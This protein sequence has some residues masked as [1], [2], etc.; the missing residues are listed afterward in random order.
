MDEDG[1]HVMVVMMIGTSQRAPWCDMGRDLMGRE[2]GI[3]QGAAAD[4]LR[5]KQLE[6]TTIKDKDGSPI[7]YVGF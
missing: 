4:H 1:A 2:G 7:L 5:R 3:Q 6:K